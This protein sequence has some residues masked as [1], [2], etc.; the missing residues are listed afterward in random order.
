M[1]QQ[2][3]SGSG[4]RRNTGKAGKK[5]SS[6]AKPALE[7]LP[8][9]PDSSAAEENTQAEASTPK[10][11]HA[12][13]RASPRNTSASRD[14]TAGAS[15]KLD[16]SFG[17]VV[18]DSED[19]KAPRS[20]G[21]VTEQKKS[22]LADSS[23]AGAEGTTAAQQANMQRPR[24]RTASP[25]RGRG[26]GAGGIFVRNAHHRQN[27]NRQSLG[28]S[29][30]SGQS[31][32]S[33]YKNQHDQG[34][35]MN[36]GVPAND[37]SVSAGVIDENSSSAAL[38]TRAIGYSG[39]DVAQRD[40]GAGL[41]AAQRRRGRTLDPEHLATKQLSPTTT[42]DSS[43]KD[44]RKAQ[45]QNLRPAVSAVSPHFSISTSNAALARYDDNQKL[46]VLTS[47]PVLPVKTNSGSSGS[48]VQ[49]VEIKHSPQ[50]SI[51]SV[52]QL[53]AVPRGQLSK[54]LYKET[55]AANSVN[56]SQKSLE[57][58]GNNNDDNHS[59]AGS[60]SSVGRT[61][62]RGSGAESRL[63]DYKGP[64]V[65]QT[66]QSVFG[67]GTRQ[68]APDLGYAAATGEDGEQQAEYVAQSGSQEAP[69]AY[70]SQ[71]GSNQSARQSLRQSQ[72]SA[73]SMRPGQSPSDEAW[74]ISA[75]AKP[76]GRLVG[77]DATRDVFSG[78][79][80]ARNAGQKNRHSR[81]I[82][83]YTPPSDQLVADSAAAAAGGAITGAK[84]HQFHTTPRTA[85][86]MNTPSLTNTNVLSPSDIANTASTIRTEPSS[87]ENQRM[88]RATDVVL[89]TDFLHHRRSSNASTRAMPIN[90]DE[91]SILPHLN[92][93]GSEMVPSANR[94]V[95]SGSSSGKLDSIHSGGYSSDPLKLRSAGTELYDSLNGRVPASPWSFIPSSGKKRTLKFHYS[96]RWNAIAA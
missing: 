85:R 88:S 59:V 60:I 43:A 5:S 90:I 13:A 53:N 18:P 4:N 32:T 36:N 48:T 20:A 42:G 81:G 30:G 31:S 28:V 40:N 80:Q 56:E 68:N 51:H 76:H 14:A 45:A 63:G 74:D 94:K 62:R 50:S 61:K 16:I 17:K 91:P 3:A 54:I 29:H 66:Q 71:A 8:E 96:G 93:T 33:P 89:D 34:S 11:K 26:R 70:M 78:A 27:A 67:Y 86:M 65:R 73:H 41:S 7:P 9:L 1:S 10:S 52:E 46:Q 83:L 44:G 55:S 92:H 24:S 47:R 75:N 95:V 87:A 38:G 72:G 69:S 15:S 23:V 25:W 37:G 2:R 64:L 12:K 77:R 79:Q 19:I 6:G 82:W 49:T 57:D 58:V 22:T 84:I 21:T 39:G 35:A